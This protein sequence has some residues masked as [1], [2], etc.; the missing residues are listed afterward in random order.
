[1]D[2]IVREVAKSQTQLSDFHLSLF[3][4]SL[5]V[6]FILHSISADTMQETPV[7]FLGWE[8][9]LEKG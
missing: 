6:M 8:D 2:C 7:R 4:M 1:M 3:H 5:F 9:L